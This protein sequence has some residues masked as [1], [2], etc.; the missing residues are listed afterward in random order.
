MILP[1]RSFVALFVL[2]ST[3]ARIEEPTPD[4]LLEQSSPPPHTDTHAKLDAAPQPLDTR[5][6]EDVLAVAQ[7]F[8]QWGHLED[9]ARWA[10]YLCAVPPPAPA[11][12]SAAE[13]SAEHARK[14]YV[15]SALDTVPLGYPSSILYVA[16]DLEAPQPMA[17]LGPEVLQAVVKESFEPHRLDEHDDVDGHGLLPAEHDGESF[18]A[19]DPLGLYIM[20]Q[21]EDRSG[22]DEGWVYATVAADLRTITAMGVIESCASCHAHAGPGRLF[23]ARP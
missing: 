21:V 4:A 6:S 13:E 8:H 12:I 20:L 19:G 23:A 9:E 10:P 7:S 16:P 11:R 17:E 2:A 3:C 22:T 1:M 15:V 5:W 14:L 18:V